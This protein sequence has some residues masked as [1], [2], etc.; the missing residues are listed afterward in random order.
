MPT[1]G[2]IQPDLNSLDYHVRD[3]KEINT[4]LQ[5]EFSEVIGERDVRSCPC[6]WRNAFILYEGTLECTYNCL[7]G[8]T[9]C[10]SS[11]MWGY[12]FGIW[13]CCTIWY[14]TPCFRFVSM[15]LEVF[16]RFYRAYLQTYVAPSYEACGMCLSNIRVQKI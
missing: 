11:I 6:V 2:P 16:G 3:P 10:C 13:A 9:C 7:T 14:I 1:C 8:L 4:A 5:I 15:M 12:L